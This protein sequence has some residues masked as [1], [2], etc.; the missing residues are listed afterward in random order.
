MAKQS[1]VLVLGEALV[2]VVHQGG[3]V[4]EHVGGSP[5]NVAFGLGRLDHDVTLAA[6]FAQDE[7]G[8][9]IAQ[10]C[11]DSGVKVAEGSDRASR[12]SVANAIIDRSGKATYQ[13]ELSWLLPTLP[14]EEG[15]QVRHLHT[16]SIGATLEPGGS[17]VVSAL[18][19]TWADATVS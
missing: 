4:T 9:R 13:F 19:D 2:D 3:R 5:A 8:N 6:W 10:A 15:D 14:A 17:Q 7:R 12:T 11:V 16:G 1:P 18:R